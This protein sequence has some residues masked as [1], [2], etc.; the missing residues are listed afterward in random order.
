M[1]HSELRARELCRRGMQGVK[2]AAPNLP[3]LQASDEGEEGKVMRVYDRWWPWRLGTIL[4]ETAHT[5]RVKW[6]DGVVWV[7]DRA[8]RKFLEE[9]R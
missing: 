8:H 1:R 5:T 7:Y 6:D 2:T 3:Q 9:S 4:S